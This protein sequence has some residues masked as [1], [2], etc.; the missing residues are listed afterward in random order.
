MLP[1]MSHPLR[2]LAR[3]L[4]IAAATGPALRAQTTLYLANGDASSL[5]AINTST[6]AFTF[7][8]TSSSSE[9]AIAVRDTI[10]LRPYSGPVTAHEYSI[11]TGAPTGLTATISATTPSEQW[12]DGTT[13][14]T[15]N[16]TLGW[17]GGST[18]NIYRANGDWSGASLLFNT[19]PL[20]LGSDLM[21]ITYDLAS[22]NF[23]IS[24]SSMISQIH[25]DGTTATLVSQ[26][27]HAGGRG[28]LAYQST[29][30]TLW[31][32]PNSSSASILQY[33]KSGTLLQSL[34]TPTRSSNIWGSEF[35]MI[36][37]PSTYVLLGLGLAGLLWRNRRRR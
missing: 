33:S 29:T 22:G 10:W 9:Y 4:L 5:Q 25:F 19:S 1:A 6:G 24:G 17:T 3:L 28:S 16:Y 27:S 32:V 26:F 30:D 14:G 35:Q 15:F 21:G 13:D 31:Y 8:V 7:N 20:S 12:L 23:W 18:V 2:L 34:T 11:T 37:E 36:P